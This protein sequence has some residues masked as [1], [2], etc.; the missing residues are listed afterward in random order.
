MC[1]RIS[2]GLSGLGKRFRLFGSALVFLAGIQGTHAQPDSEIY[3]IPVLP[4][5]DSL[6][7]G[8]PVNITENPGYDN[9]PS[10]TGDGLL[11]YSRTRAGQTDIARYDPGTG[12]LQW[13]SDTPGGS[14]YSPLPIPGTRDISAIRLDTSGLQRLYRYNSDTSRLMLKDL[15]VGYHLWVSPDILVCTVLT[16]QGMDLVVAR[17]GAG[18]AYTHQKNVGRS[19][20][21]IPGTGRISFVALEGGSPTLKSMDPVSGATSEIT[22]LPE[23]MQD[24]CWWDERTVVGGQGNALL[25]YRTDGDGKW[26]MGY[27]LPP[28]IGRISRLALNPGGDLL[29]LVAEPE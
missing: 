22:R 28:G 14:E 12:E 21:R 7:L 4:N 9:Q 11:L 3:L 16:E 2:A 8:T 29:A 27:R 13:L 26:T 5:S 19:L 25:L 6:L 24:I 15:K 17:P 23:G 10:F 18:N 1:P 20:Q